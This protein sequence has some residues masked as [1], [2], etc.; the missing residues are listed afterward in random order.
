[1]AT[2]YYGQQ[3]PPWVRMPMEVWTMI[4]CFMMGP[5]SLAPLWFNCRA[6]CRTFR[7]AVEVVVRNH[8][9]PRLS[10]VFNSDGRSFAKVPNILR[11]IAS[12]T[13][14]L[15][16]KFS[17]LC[18]DN[19]RAAFYVKQNQLKNVVV[20]AFTDLLLPESL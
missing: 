5:G 11:H 4:M 9:L 16:L 13:D 17:R 14:T 15:P 8:V 12:K 2:V 1:M 7:D 18:V 10:L 19:S 6:V 20:D 3:F